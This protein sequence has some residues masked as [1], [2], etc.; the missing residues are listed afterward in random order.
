M[1]PKHPAPLE[2]FFL[3]LFAILLFR[4]GT[5]RDGHVLISLSL[6]PSLPFCLLFLSILPPSLPSLHLL[7][8]P[9]AI[10]NSFL[11]TG[12]SS[13][14]EWSIGTVDLYK[15]VALSSKAV[16]C[17]CVHIELLLCLCVPFCQ[18]KGVAEING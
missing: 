13:H 11:F 2:P 5:G 6:P 10:M 1:F 8:P 9:S 4:I 17:V 14:M 3:F 12:T 15:N 7:L 18:G 16:H